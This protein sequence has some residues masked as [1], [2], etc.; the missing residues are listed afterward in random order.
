MARKT[1]ARKEV[2]QDTTGTYVRAIGWEPNQKKPGEFKPHRFYLGK[3]GA[4]A[5]IRAIRLEQV[6][7]GIEKQWQKLRETAR[8]CWD[9]VSC[10]SG[11]ASVGASKW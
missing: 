10:K 11:W 8:A 3:D 1:G 5:Q 7:A 6:W 2:A 9:E 4:E